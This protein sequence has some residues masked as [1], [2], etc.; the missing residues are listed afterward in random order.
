MGMDENYRHVRYIADCIEAVSDGRAYIDGNGEL[1]VVDIDE[2]MPDDV[3]VIDMREYFDD[4]YDI[5][6]YIGGRDDYRGARIMVACGGPNIYV[7]SM[8]RDV[9]LYWWGEHATCDL[10]CSACEDI[11]EVFREYFECCY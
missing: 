10:S 7:D 4:V 2:D 3:E 11:T 1:I 9:E 8:R 5:V 6:H